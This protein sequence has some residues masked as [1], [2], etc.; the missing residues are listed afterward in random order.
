MNRTNQIGEKIPKVSISL[1]TYNQ[2]DFIKQAIDSVLMQETNFKY[3]LIIGEDDS[4][5]GTRE[6][7][8]SYQEKYPHK[9]R[10]FLNKR[11]DVIF[12]D[13]K[14]TGNWNFINNLQHCKGKY[15]ALLEGDDYWTDPNKLQKQADFL[16]NNPDHSMC[17]HKVHFEYEDSN[18]EPIVYEPYK[19]KRSYSLEELIQKNFISTLSAVYRN[20]EFF[21]NLPEWFY[22]APVCDYPMHLLTAEKGSIGYINDQMGVRRLHEKGYWSSMSLEKKYDT[23]LQIHDLIYTYFE[24]GKHSNIAKSSLYYSK[25]RVDYV[26]KDYYSSMINLFK[27]LYLVPGHISVHDRGML[28]SVLDIFIPVD[29]RNDIRR[30]IN[31]KKSS[32]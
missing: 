19:Q 15:I 22:S 3:E 4:T 7:V 17:F 29:M 8:L 24:S 13:G 28:K 32:L 27:C 20:Y 21:S 14:P 23:S 31:S 9:I 5:D 16:D 30:F 25:H 10:T 26:R 11:E 6:I 18:L 2:V 12:I 1:I